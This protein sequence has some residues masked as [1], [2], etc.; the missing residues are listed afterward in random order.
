M[1]FVGF[2]GPSYTLK[3]VDVDCQRCINLYPE[4]DETGTGK[5]KE[6]ASLVSTPGLKLFATVGTGPIRGV[7][8]SSSGRLFAVSGNQFY[9]V[10][11]SGVATL[12]GTIATSSGQVSF[13]DNGIQLVFVDGTNGYVFTLA[14]NAFA[15]ITDEDFLGA[16]LVTYQDGYFIFNRPGT[17]YMFFSG[18]NDTTFDALDFK[19]AEGSPDVLVSVLSNGR[20][21]WMFGDNTTEIFY[22]SGDADMPFQRIQG[23]FVEYGC[24]AKH[25]VAKLNN[26]VIWLGKNALGGGQVFMATGYQPQRIST[27]AVEQAIQSYSTIS[28]ATAYAYQE[29]GHSFYVLNFSVAQTTWVFDM[30]TNLWHERAYNNQGVLER[31]RA[32]SHAYVFA[33]HIVGDYLTGKLYE[34]SSAVYSDN[35]VEI[36][37]RRVTPHLTQELVRI[38]YNSFQ[39]DIEAGTG[40]DGVQQGTDPQAMLQFSDDSGRTWSNEKWV[41]FGKIGQTKKRALWRRLG[42]SRDR[43]FRITIT[44]PVRVTLIGAELNLVAGAN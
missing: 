21:L 37:R 7:F 38:F 30:T 5:E 27:H 24:A 26:T 31:H 39:L 20:E 29:N 3:S 14:T 9:E 35:G 15:A 11:S 44:D 12:R 4:I 28:D 18:L 22:D 25:S 34:L 43:V 6:V 13:A 33:K 16:D 23:A 36:V 32:S 1:R 40:L 17:G 19:A 10:S 42:S 41:S 2:I 8:A